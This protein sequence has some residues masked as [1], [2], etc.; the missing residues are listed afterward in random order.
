MVDASAAHPCAGSGHRT[1][2]HTA[3][4]DE[5]FAIDVAMP[6]V[7]D[8]DGNSSLALVIPVQPGWAGG[9]AGIMLSGPRG[10]VTVDGDTDVPMTILLDPST[11]EVRGILHDVPETDAAAALAPQV[12]VDGRDVL[13]SRGVPGAAAW[14]R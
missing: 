3:T 8:G 5:L 13:Y 14:D 2:R 10:S 1:S 11:G 12:G 6:E 4:G 9:P 7:A